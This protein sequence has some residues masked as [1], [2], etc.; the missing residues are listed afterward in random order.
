MR[1]AIR[2]RLVPQRRSR[3]QAITEF[4]L[5]APILLLLLFA[6]LE[7]GFLLFTVGTARFAAGEAARQLS[8]DGNAASADQNA[9]AVIR[10][11]GLGTTSLGTVT[12]VDIYRLNQQPDGSLT[13]D[14]AH[15]NSY[16]IGGAPLGAITWPSITRDIKNG[17]M[18]F[19][20]ITVYYRYNWK[21]GFF[22]GGSPLQLN[23][24]IYIRLEP[25]L[26]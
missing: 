12:K 3:G 4:A 2:P 5:V 25:Q 6:V 10:K 1:R 16:Q 17:E 23:H 21:T 18:D 11:T 20:G 22:N 15:F 9:L 14:P 19:L 24:A 7:G 13:V 26:Y 8:E